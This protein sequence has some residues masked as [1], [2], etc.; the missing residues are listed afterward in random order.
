MTKM[1][2]RKRKA[3]LWLAVFAAVGCGNNQSGAP[4]NPSSN[5][6]SDWLKSLVE[7]PL[8]K[9]PNEQKFSTEFKRV[10]A[11]SDEYYFLFSNGKR[12]LASKRNAEISS[13]ILLWECENEL[14]SCIVAE[15][16]LYLS[17]YE[18]AI[19]KHD[20]LSGKTTKIAEMK[21]LAGRCVLQEFI[22]ATRDELAMYGYR[23]DKNGRDILGCNL[24]IMKDG[25]LEH[26]YDVSCEGGVKV[27][28][29]NDRWIQAAQK[30]VQ[31]RSLNKTG[32]IIRQ[33]P[34]NSSCFFIKILPS[35]RVIMSGVQG[36]Y[37]MPITMIDSERGTEQ[38]TRFKGFS[39]ELIEE[40]K[41]LFI[42]T[43]NRLY[44]GDLSNGK[45]TLVLDPGTAELALLYHRDGAGFA[46]TLEVKLTPDPRAL[47][48]Y[49]FDFGTL[50]ML[51]VKRGLISRELA[52][53]PKKLIQKRLAVDKSAVETKLTT[54]VRVEKHRP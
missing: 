7:T 34:M 13:G 41:I 24:W 33:I 36:G 18:G 40:E 22:G 3:I 53:I 8:E 20:L 43:Q 37:A 29:K 25:K 45:R 51:A 23:F 9:P 30:S 21:L 39:A 49:F 28:F 10:E 12:L 16:I 46:R 4:S 1:T 38:I 52:L 44:L 47:G 48:L 14:I 35:K 42:E 2:S 50:T 32:S 6:T 17:D 19:W 26:E 27:D 15:N 54:F 5:S 11:L 31:I